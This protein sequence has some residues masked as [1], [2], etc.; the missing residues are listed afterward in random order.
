MATMQFIAAYFA[1]IACENAGVPLGV[2][3]ICN[4]MHTGRIHPS[5]GMSV[6]ADQLTIFNLVGDRAVRT[7][8]RR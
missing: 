3:G 5:K 6:S 7:D 2:A 8:Y 4:D 1:V